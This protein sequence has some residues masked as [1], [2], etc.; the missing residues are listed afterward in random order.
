MFAWDIAFWFC[1]LNP[2]ENGV[3]RST[4]EGI[5]LTV[6]VGIPLEAWNAFWLPYVGN[7]T[8]VRDAFRAVFQLEIVTIMVGDPP[9]P[10]EV[11]RT[12]DPVAYASW[13]L[14]LLTPEAACI[15]GCQQSTVPQ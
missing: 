15:S 4:I 9:I 11:V 1:C 7:G 8:A 3:L 6:N 10:L 5:A 12:I 2:R 13:T 14:F